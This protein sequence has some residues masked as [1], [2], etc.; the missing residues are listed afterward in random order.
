MVG[1]LERHVQRFQKALREPG[2]IN[3]VLT[4]VEDNVGVDRIYIAP[5]AI[6]FLAVYLVLGFGAQLVCNTI[7][8]VYPAYAS[9]KAI[10]TNSKD[11]DTKWL[12]YWVVYACFGM[13]EFFSDILL[14]WFPLYW[15]GKCVF[16]IFC[17]APVSWN[18]SNIIYRNIIRPIF[19]NYESEV[20]QVAMMVESEIGQATTKFISTVQP[21]LAAGAKSLSDSLNENYL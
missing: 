17:F 21:K 12:T 10:E 5:G 8:F 2:L 16:L 11:D 20:E 19:L 13:V 3:D 4:I 6:G 7:G 1:F 18:G 15:L 9:I 14:S